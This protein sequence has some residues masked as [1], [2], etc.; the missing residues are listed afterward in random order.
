MRSGRLK[1]G[2]PEASSS[3]DGVHEV[4]EGACTENATATSSHS[5]V[6]LGRSFTE[7]DEFGLMCEAATGLGRSAAAARASAVQALIATAV[8]DH[9]RAAVGAAW[10]VCLGL[11]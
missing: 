1:F 9:D 8:A 3:S 6:R 4:S 7:G 10:G 11:E 2:R 5:R